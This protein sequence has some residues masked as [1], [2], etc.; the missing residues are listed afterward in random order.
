[1]SPSIVSILTL[2]TIGVSVAG[3]LSLLM[4][5][6]PRYKSR[7]DKRLDSEFKQKIAARAHQSTQLFRD[8]GKITSASTFGNKS[9]NERL[10]LL[11][12]QAGMEPQC[13]GYL[14]TTLVL[15]VLSGVAAFCISSRPLL[16]IVSMLAVVPAPCLFL[17]AKGRQRRNVLC[18][19]LPEACE[20]MSG[21]VRAGQTLHRAFQLVATESP[22]PLA[23][24]F[25]YCNDQQ[26]MGMPTEAALR[27]LARRTG[28]VELKMLA[29]V[30][31][32]Q[33]QTGGNSAELL[34]N[35]SDVL[36]KRLRFAGKLKALSA[37]SRMQAS[38]LLV[39]PFALFAAMYFLSRGYAELLLANPGI[40]GM[41]LL[42]EAVGAIWIW[43]IINVD[44]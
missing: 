34:N 2:S 40:I 7:V 38:L 8:L 28:I 9:L 43:H 12:E 10:E 3:V 17:I 1:M 24:E 11:F 27:D 19:Q 32:I 15:S 4:D 13:K 30:L 25:S 35:L 42:S 26:T 29:V 37:E 18:A 6:V 36:R 5:I 21:A 31:L 41:T 33:R 14:L 44:Y 23:E 39:L 16:T 22:A 20:M